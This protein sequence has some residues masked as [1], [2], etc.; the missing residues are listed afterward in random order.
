MRNIITHVLR[1]V[2]T[3]RLS[4]FEF[5]ALDTNMAYTGAQR[6]IPVIS[7]GRLKYVVSEL[8]PIRAFGM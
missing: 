8:L 6:S 2:A 1:F 5:G 4:K 7:L 3:T